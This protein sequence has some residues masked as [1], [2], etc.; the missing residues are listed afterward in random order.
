MINI[1]VRRDI[2]P[3]YNGSESGKSIKLN[4]FNLK[5][6]IQKSWNLA[7]RNGNNFN[8][9]WDGKSDMGDKLPSAVYIVIFETG[10]V[11]QYRK[12]FLIK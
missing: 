6:Q 5:G 12:I 2:H 7:G 9:L 11:R 8:L 1:S 10:S 4:I 3:G